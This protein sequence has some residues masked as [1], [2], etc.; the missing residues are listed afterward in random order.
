MPDKYWVFDF[1][2]G[3]NSEWDCPYDYQVGRYDEHRPGMYTTELF[4]N[5]RDL[6]VG[7]DLGGP[8]GTP[9]YAFW[10]GTIHS[11]GIN[12]EDGSYG[13]TIITEHFVELPESVGSLT[14]RPK[15]KLWVL[16]GHLSVDSLDGLVVG[17]KV[18]RGQEI[19]RIGCLE[20]NGGWPPHLHLQL[21]LIKPLVNDL[22]G[23]VKLTNR[24]EALAIYPDPRLI[25]GCLY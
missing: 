13:P 2:R 1:T 4:A 12:P 18:V 23:V 11:F 25:V 8:V 15:T 17:Q 6:H 14:M 9:V 19:A 24:D 5:E 21:S 7:L 16:H 22:P 10:D 3:P 20:E